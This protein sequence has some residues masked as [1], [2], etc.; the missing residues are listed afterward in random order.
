MFDFTGFKKLPT[1]RQ[2]KQCS[3]SNGEAVLQVR[4]GSQDKSLTATATLPHTDENDNKLRSL[5]N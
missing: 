3:I 2:T 5:I 1:S 4:D